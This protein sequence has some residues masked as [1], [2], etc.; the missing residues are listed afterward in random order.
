MNATTQP[1]PFSRDR[2][3]WLAY[4]MLGYLGFSQAVLGPLMPSLRSE[5]GLSYTQGGFLSA[6]IAFGLV[7]SGLTGGWLARRVSRTNLFWGGGVA[8][9]LSISLLS[10]SYAFGMVLLAVLC[11]GIGGSLT[12]AMIQAL[13]SDHHQEKRAIALTEANVGASLS[14]T[15]T[16]LAIGLMQ[17]G[18]ISWRYLAIFALSAMA[19]I[20]LIF[21]QERIPNSPQSP[22]QADDSRS[23]LPVTFWIFW[24][25]LFFMVSTEM[26]LSI[27]STDFFATVIHLSRSNAVLAYSAFPSAMLIGRLAGTWL[28]RH[29][30]AMILLF[31]ELALTFAGFLMFWLSRN[32]PLNILGLFITGLGAANQYPLALSIAVGAAKEKSNQASARISLAVGAALLI[33]P[34]FLGMT[35]DRLGLQQAFGMVL[36]LVSAT[37]IIIFAGTNM[38]N[39]TGQS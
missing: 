3:T 8:L 29:Y 1:T 39:K 7:I 11:M 4:I 13:L 16:P 33:A 6:A 18:G 14:G 36:V 37:I 24:G 12:Q 34:S 10:I 15:L 22:A 2:L 20:T 30:P 26:T 9:A 35:A 28:T 25:V 32:A 23:N 5:L 31:I 27:W 17:S 21:R 38:L 19:V